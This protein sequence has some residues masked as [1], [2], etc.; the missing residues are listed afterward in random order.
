MIEFVQAQVHH[1]GPVLMNMRAQERKTVAKLRIDP[2]MLLQSTIEKGAPSFTCFIDDQPVAM[3]GLDSTSIIG[4]NQW[5][6]MITTAEVEKHQLPLLR[7]SKRFVQWAH[8]CY[9]PVGGMVDR[10]NDI[11]L[12]WLK[13][14]GF[15]VVEDGEYIK[16]R[17]G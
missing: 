10:E 14:I 5:L 16:L 2:L 8:K 7:W 3:F 4:A 13:W 11:S 6:W 15:T 1:A 9:G 12:K 17:Y